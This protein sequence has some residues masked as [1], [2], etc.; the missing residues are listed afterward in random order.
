[1]SAVAEE[2]RGS[3]SRREL[4]FNGGEIRVVQKFGCIGPLGR[5]P[6][7]QQCAHGGQRQR[8]MAALAK[9]VTGCRGKLG[10]LQTCPERQ[11]LAR[12]RRLE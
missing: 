8:Q 12:L 2:T 9:D 5:R 4:F 3:M 10:D 1:M 11:Q 6:L 7:A